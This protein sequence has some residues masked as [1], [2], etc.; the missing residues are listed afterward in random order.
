MLGK[1]ERPDGFDRLV[2]VLMPP[3]LSLVKTRDGKAFVHPNFHMAVAGQGVGAMPIADLAESVLL[4]AVL[5]TTQE[6][7]TRLRR[8]ID[9][10]PIRSAVID[11]S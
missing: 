7:V 4:S 9:G 1:L 2:E 10:E 3:L 8:W 11:Q 5:T 6:T